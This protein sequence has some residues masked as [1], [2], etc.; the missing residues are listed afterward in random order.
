MSAQIKVNGEPRDV[1][2]PTTLAALLRQ[3]N[4]DAE[5]SGV[6]VARNGEIVRRALWDET[7]VRPGDELE[8]VGATQGG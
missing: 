7:E 6:A 1:E 5:R 2:T 8:I 4:V 3:L